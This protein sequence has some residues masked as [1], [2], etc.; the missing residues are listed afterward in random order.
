[1]GAVLQGLNATVIA[2]QGR[3][4]L[5]CGGSGAGKSDLALRCLAS[6]GNSL[7]PSE[8]RLVADDYVTC[9]RVGE[10]LMVSAPASI[11]GKI[12]VR[13]LGIVTLPYVS[14]VAAGL[15]VDLGGDEPIDRLPDPP[16][17]RELLGVR[18]PVL[19]VN[20]FEAS[21]ALK[22]LLALLSGWG[23]HAAAP[24]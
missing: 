5:I 7:I 24:S 20:A 21:A 23:R 22:V 1:V 13:G 4:G 12:E 3:A 17:T 16:E 10:R 19:R 8:V 9:E 2:C 15:I 6:G 14:P 11:A 18:L